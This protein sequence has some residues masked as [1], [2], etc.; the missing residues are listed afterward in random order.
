VKGARAGMSDGLEWARRL[1]LETAVEIEQLSSGARK[2]TQ[3]TANGSFD[4]TAQTIILLQ[5]RFAQLE[6]F[7]D[8][9]PVAHIN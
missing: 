6:N 1:R 7:I 4:I 9:F 8:T 3:V 5:D 2:I